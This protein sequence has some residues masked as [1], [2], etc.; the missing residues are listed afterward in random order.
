MAAHVITV[1]HMAVALEQVDDG[2]IGCG[3]AVG[4]RGALQSTR[5]PWMRCGSGLPHAP[6]GICPHQRPL[7]GRLPGRDPS[8]PV[9]EPAERLQLRRLPHKGRQAPNRCGPCKRRRRWL[10]APTSSYKLRRAPPGPSPAP[11]LGGCPRISVIGSLNPGWPIDYTP[12][13]GTALDITLSLQGHGGS[14]AS[15]RSAPG[16]LKP[17]DEAPYGLDRAQTTPIAPNLEQIMR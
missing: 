4:H 14:S 6:G 15:R 7:P 5:Q 8:A 11:A 1:V 12:G 17:I 10:L 3:L 13:W 16:H 9:S 2:E